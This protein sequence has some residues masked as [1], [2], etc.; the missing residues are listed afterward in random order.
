[1][2]KHKSK[3][4]LN[5]PLPKSSKSLLLSLLFLLPFLSAAQTVTVD[6]I[7][8]IGNKK[9][10]SHVVLRELNFQIGDTLNLDNMMQ[11]FAEN[12]LLLLNTGIFTE[13]VF[14]IKNW[15]TESKKAQVELTVKEALPIL[16]VPIF[17]LADRNFNVWWKEMNRDLE[18]INYGLIL[19]HFNLT[20]RRDK[21]KLSGQRG[22]T[23][24]AEIDYT[25]PGIN[26]SQT[27]GLGFNVLFARNKEVSFRTFENRLEFFKSEDTFLYRRFRSSVRAFYR[28]KLFSTHRLELFYHN[29]KVDDFVNTDLNP[30]FFGDDKTR[31]SYFALQYNFICDKR[32]IK[33]Y[34]SKGYLVSASLRKDGLGIMK[35]RNSFYLTS[36]FAKYI[37]L[38]KRFSIEAIAQGRYSFVRKQ[39][40]YFDL[41]ALGFNEDYIRGYEFYVID[42]LDYFYQKTALRFEIFS[43]DINFGK[44]SPFEALR[45]M[46]TR[47]YFNLNNDLGYT[48]D[49]Y[50][51]QGNPLNNSLLWGRGVGLDIIVYY[52]LVVQMEYS[53]NRLGEGGFFLHIRAGFN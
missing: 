23:R 51:S 10:K 14:N 5:I 42:G 36:R 16:P 52:A 15:D 20:G 30:A 29:N 38:S 18:R 25:L 47:V 31:L 41:K 21:L 22:Y 13:A 49:P 53:I 17:E 46:N 9:T 32:D 40:P 34:P 6:N 19:Y 43:G 37:P 48:N 11:R 26:K 4:L 12:R 35:D 1:M 24:K 3:K 39:Q 44:L 7:S 50:F 33:P 2:P 8:I 27:I 28:P 45:K